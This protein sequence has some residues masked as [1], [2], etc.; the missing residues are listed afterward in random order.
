MPNHIAGKKHQARLHSASV[1]TSAR[2]PCFYW[3]QGKCFK[4]DACQYAHL[5]MPGATVASSG[6]LTP[7]ATMI[8][9]PTPARAADPRPFLRGIAILSCKF[10]LKKRAVEEGTTASKPLLP[11]KY[12]DLL[13]RK[14]DVNLYIVGG[15][16]VWQFAFNEQVKEAIKTHIRGRQ[17]EPSVGAKGSWTC[18]LESLPDAIALYEHLGRTPDA[19]LKQRCSDIIAT[20]GSAAAIDCIKL[21]IHV[22]Q[23]CSADVTTIGRAVVSFQYDADLVAALKC[24]AP[25]YRSY[26][27]TS[28]EWTIDLLSLPELL[29][30]LNNVGY[31]PPDNLRSIANVLVKVESMLFI[32]PG[33]DTSPQNKV[34]RSPSE[35][36]VVANSGPVLPV[37]TMAN[38]NPAKVP[39]R[40]DNLEQHAQLQAA[41][42]ELQQM[43]RRVPH[44]DQVAA[45]DRSDCGAE[46]RRRLTSSQIRYALGEAGYRDS[47]D[48]LS[49]SG[50]DDFVDMSFVRG[51]SHTLNAQLGEAPT[52]SVNCSCGQPWR[53]VSGKHI[54]RFFGHFECV[55]GNRWTS[56][57]CWDGEKQACRSCNRESFPYQKDP[58]DGRPGKGTGPHDSSR[59]SMCARLG[60][61]CSERFDF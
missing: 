51:F 52:L 47:D 2:N 31:M 32:A 34:E 43:L 28:K 6:D 5:G 26:D 30:H 45:I 20:H 46:K 10:L 29:H 8:S 15:K 44:G 49:G 57:Y 1:V 21:I 19:Q 11:E 55:C 9:I 54:C 42:K 48:E 16:V 4:G 24:L 12:R 61:D 60:R 7:P 17:W 53:R 59:C 39:N 35:E 18:P 23:P 14:R 38:D 33:G 58:L 13:K 27:A 41:F 50:F 37:T 3:A 56:A 25:P 36:A 22:D 40:C